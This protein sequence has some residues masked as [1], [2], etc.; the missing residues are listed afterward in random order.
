MKRKKTNGRCA[1]LT[2]VFSATAGALLIGFLVL[3]GGVGV[4]DDPDG[5]GGGG[6]GGSDGGWSA[7][8]EAVGTL[9]STHGLS[10]LGAEGEQDLPTVFGRPS[11]Y[12]QGPASELFPA[13]MQA[14]G[15]GYVTFEFLGGSNGFDQNL[16]IVFHGELH[17]AFDAAVFLHPGVTAGLKVGAVY[18]DVAAAILH[19]DR[20]VARHKIYAETTFPVPLCRL[21]R[22][23]T[24]DDG[25]QLVTAG[26]D[27]HRNAIE[28]TG[29][30]GIVTIHQ[31]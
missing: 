9:P 21:M 30:A 7:D 26:E 5:H 16:R 12:I 6:D 13:L 23:G 8:N 24:L 27:G 3:F 19:Q 31:L 1:V 2:R 18:G 17:L 20:L 25:V 29:Y 14:D 28:I 15:V 4:A 10:H 22:L 11:F